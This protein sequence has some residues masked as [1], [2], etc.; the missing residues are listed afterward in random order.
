MP[1]PQDSAYNHLH[2]QPSAYGW[3]H[4]WIR[5]GIARFMV[6]VPFALQALRLS[7]RAIKAV[8]NTTQAYQQTREQVQRKRM[9]GANP[10]AFDSGFGYESEL[11][12]LEVLAHY[13][14]QL[15]RGY[16]DQQRTESGVV[17]E[18]LINSVSDLLETFPEL[19][20]AINFGVSYA[21]IDAELAKKFPS[22]R[23]IGLDRSSLTKWYNDK[24][25]S[26]PNLSIQTA[27]IFDCLK[28]AS[29]PQSI[30]LH[31]RTLN[32]LPVDFNVRLYT[33]AQQAGCR[34]IVGIEQ[35]G[36]S[37][38]T[39]QPYSFSGAEKESV[40]Y[41]NHMFIHNYPSLLAASGYRIIRSQLL[42]TRHPDPNY[43][44]VAFVAEKA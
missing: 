21:H 42:A 38:E 7:A 17:Y 16:L 37:W 25:F 24:H 4:H 13:H 8:E 43:R 33:A 6:H 3:I 40:V 15:Q 19:T 1:T 9:G 10:L 44:L 18:W 5:Q 31:A 28:P 34:Y 22:R 32:L 30:L 27:D 39:Q 14:E 11:R 26:L 23:F 41:R 35:C 29:Q 20:H 36:I 2:Y 12:E